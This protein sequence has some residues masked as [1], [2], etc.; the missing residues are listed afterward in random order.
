MKYDEEGFLYPHSDDRCVH[1]DKCAEV[2][3]I[4]S[5]KTQ[6]NLDIQQFAVAA[7][8]NDNE[9][10]KSSSSGGA[11]SAICDTYCD[12]NT[13]IFG[14]TF[15]GVFVKHGFVIGKKNIH[16]FRK[17]KYVQSDMGDCFS[18]VRK[19]LELN[20][21]VLFSGTPCQ[22]SGL[23]SYLGKN[24]ENLFCVDFICYG[25]G[26]PKVF[27]D[28]LKYISKYYKSE[29]IRYT[30]RVKRMY[31]GNLDTYI[32]SYEFKNGRKVKVSQD[33][34][35]S[36]FLKQLCHRKSCGE[37]CRYRHQYRLSD[38]TIAD[39]KNQ[40]GIFPE[41][42]E[43]RN[44]STIIFN[45]KKGS[46]LFDKIKGLMTVIPCNMSAIEQYNPLFFKQT[47]GNPDRTAFFEDYTNGME[48]FDLLSNYY[49]K[50]HKSIKSEISKF[51]P[52]WIKYKLKSLFNYK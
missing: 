44:L 36:A 26:S 3:P 19:F 39:F 24:Y 25:V 45:T 28:W 32:S 52:Y 8:N 41:I 38:I 42:K 10:W 2:C 29:I 37:S 21:R 49:I 1:C 27:E 33:L 13:V 5:H 40:S 12:D 15:D 31:I 9:I 43:R 23:K 48:I 22:V 6:G 16:V 20:H 35:V 14:A 50:P 30:F 4:E 7:V 18:K 46:I 34:Y 47:S 11:F 17:S 51:I